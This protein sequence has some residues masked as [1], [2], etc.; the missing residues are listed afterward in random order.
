L[1]GSVYYLSPSG[2]LCNGPLT[3]YTFEGIVRIE[4]EDSTHSA[5]DAPIDD[6]GRYSFT[7]APGTYRIQLFQSGVGQRD[8]VT[9]KKG[10]RTT[11]TLR[12]R[13]IAE[14]RMLDLRALLYCY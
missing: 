3:R 12:I 4:A 5:V 7:A 11:R 9:D 6:N 10:D 2:P 14:V 8:I 13:L 1:E